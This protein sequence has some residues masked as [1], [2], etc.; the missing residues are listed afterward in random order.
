MRSRRT[1]FAV[2][3]SLALVTALIVAV[4]PAA[5][6]T[7][8]SLDGHAPNVLVKITLGKIEDG[9]RKP[10]RSYQLL[11]PGSGAPA[12]L[13]TTNRIPI[14]TITMGQDSDGHSTPAS[15]FT[16]QNIGFQANVRAH[17]LGGGMVEINADIDDSALYNP[18]DIERGKPGQPS[19]PVVTG[20][21]QSIQA[22]VTQGTPI[23]STLVEDPKGQSIY[24]QI[25]AEILR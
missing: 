12:R 21:T 5:G 11:A 20:V 18:A 15:S 1:L 17:V 7:A 24:I 9:D 23:V 22:F 2:F 3:A 10:L 8:S 14:P 16:Y 25:G 13:S 19:A 4:V 6:D